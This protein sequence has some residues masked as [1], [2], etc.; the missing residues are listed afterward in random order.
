MTPPI[1]IRAD[2][3]RIVQN[4]LHR[5][6]PDGV[7]VWVFGSRAS[8]MTKDSSDL[9]LA[10]ERDTD[11]PAQSLSALDVAFEESDLPYAVDIVDV[12]RISE[13]F[14]RIVTHQRVRLPESDRPRPTNPNSDSVGTCPSWR[15]AALG[16]VAEFLSGGT[17]SKDQPAYWNGSIPWASAKDMK[18]FRLHDTADHVTAEGLANG[19]RE[20]PAGS[21]F[22]L[23]RGM[24][25]LNELPVCVSDRPMAFNQDVKAL[26]PRP[27]LHPGFLPYLV[28]G[29]K[30]RLL[31]L[32]DLAGHGTGRLNSD[33][34]K[35]L[36][37]LLPP[38]PEQR[39]IAHVLGT[40]DD[41][42]ELNR[43]MNATLEAMARALFRSWFVDFDPVRAKME[44]RDTGLP[45]D[46][47]DLFP[48]RLVDSELGEIP[49]GWQLKPLDSLASF[50][51]GLALQK[52]RPSQ[53]EARLPVV[54]ITQL[55]AGETNGREWASATIKSEC[56]IENGD[57]VFSWSGSLL[58][59]MWCG[60]RAALNQHL[61]KVTSEKYPKWFYLHSILAH[62][63]EFQRIAKDKA[64]TMGHI[65]RHHLTEALCVVP[66]DRVISR[67][68]DTLGGLL[69]R[70][71]ANELTR[72]T[73]VTLRDLL[74]PKLVSGELRVNALETMCEREDRPASV[75]AH[76]SLTVPPA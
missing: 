2:H 37:I 1:D 70:Q 43:R 50:Q 57:I 71:V 29:S 16:D 10:L 56:I 46:I 27:G 30:G 25:L 11:I 23:T 36:N 52:F 28:L 15:N 35:S 6:L 42:I 68:A 61:F 39:A 47:G 64:T 72:R 4:V 8:W 40:L 76:G 21:V 9:D 55:R 74:L 48:D 53:N 33:E 20:V 18:S 45:K 12:K 60:G 19:T 67:V 63:P 22:L 75:G 38:R 54:K 17:P 14:R 65:R 49:D 62:F 59:K 13:R 41:K 32:V 7:K 34:L 24:A 31:D 3:L 5:H 26:R 66:P 51:N 73:L 58:V 44:G 69:E